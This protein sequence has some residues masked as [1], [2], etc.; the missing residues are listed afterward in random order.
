MKLPFNHV[1]GLLVAALAAGV[2]ILT[3]CEN[4]PQPRKSPTTQRPATPPPKIPVTVVQSEPVQQVITMPASVISF[5]T[6]PL[7]AKID[8]YVD[9]VYVDI[10]DEVKEDDLLVQLEAPELTYEVERHEKMVVQGEAAIT[11]ARA[12]LEAAK[13]RLDEQQA[14]LDL[15]MSEQQR[16]AQIIRSGA[17]SEQ[18]G[19]EAEFALKSA[20]AAKVRYQNTVSVAE[21]EVNMAVA[22]VGVAKADYDKAKALAQYQ[23]IRAPFDGVITERKVDP[24]AFV[25]PASGEGVVPLVTVDQ[26]DK[27]RAMIHVTMDQAVYLDIGDRVELV[28]DNVPGKKFPGTVSRTA[29]VFDERTRMMRVEVD[30][31]NFPSDTTGHRPLRAGTYGE[32]TIVTAEEPLVVVPKAAIGQNV[33]GP[34]VVVVGNDGE[35][36]QVAIEVGIDAGDVVGV[37]SGIKP[38]DRVVASHP[39]QIKDKQRLTENSIR[40]LK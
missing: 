20:T 21:A 35:C 11:L 17:L 26:I 27:L 36:Q 9:K 40:E 1:T 37:L 2:A 12:E 7:M 10:G 4:P 5:E 25:R 29:G 28:V 6:A 18:K 23:Q 39:D 24:G 13:A 33:T 14:L 22:R 16:I 3:G 19:H 38:G 15:R 32:V 30:L 8:A 34:Y 31:D